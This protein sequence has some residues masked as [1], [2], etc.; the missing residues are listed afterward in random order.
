MTLRQL[1][2]FLFI[3]LFFSFSSTT[4]AQVYGLRVDTVSADIGVLAGALGTTDMTGMACYRL[5]ITMENTDDFMSSISGDATNPTYVNTSTSFYQ[6]ALGGLTA[7]SSNPLLFA[8]YPDLA[9]D[10]YVSIGL[11]GPANASAGEANPSTVQSGANPWATN[12][13]PGGGQPGGNISI[14]DAI[15]GAWYAQGLAPDWTVDGLASPAE[16]LAGPVRPI[17]T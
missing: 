16:A 11:T 3:L 13:D 14:D 4:Q 12:F 6:A 9:Y 7:S 17:L 2:S 15:G 10:S 1:T 8:F 5:Y